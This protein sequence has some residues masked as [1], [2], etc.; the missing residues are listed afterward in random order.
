MEIK[1]MLKNNQK[2]SRKVNSY[3][4]GILILLL[5]IFGFLWYSQL[6][7]T[8]DGLIN[9][10]KKSF[11]NMGKIFSE[12]VQA[13]GQT[14]LEQFSIFPKQRDYFSELREY[15]EE[16]SNA[17]LKN[18]YDSQKYEN[19]KI[20]PKF[21]KSVPYKFNTKI[22]LTLSSLREFFKVLGKI[23]IIVGAFFMLFQLGK[24]RKDPE[25]SIIILSCFFIFSILVIMPFI[26]IKYDLLRTYQ[27]VLMLLSLPA[28]L[29]GLFI[30]K[31][32]KKDYKII[33]ITI[34]FLFYFLFLS[35]FIQQASG[36]HNAIMKLNNQG[37]DYNTYYTHKLEI[38]SS[39]WLIKNY[40]QN[41]LIYADKYAKLRS[42]L[43][44]PIN[45]KNKFKTD[46]LPQLIGKKDYVHSNYAN[47]NQ[48]ITFSSFRDNL[49]S[50]NYPTQFLNDNK[51]KV[52]NNGGSEIYK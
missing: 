17:T 31:F 46:I 43:H 3:L 12:D 47:V 34:L 50:Y 14:P 35:G 18:S 29:G 19:Y 36:G 4:T 16:M 7:E 26:S 20:T 48:Q 13:Q 42:W 23:L 30:F 37:W 51:N 28:V 38:S 45:L 25:Y 6:T 5:L 39:N 1:K 32:L 27:Q 8:S 52:Y 41:N 33:F 2:N 15:N 10:T 22:V 11:T 21:S 24:Q 40:A 49:I 9:F 44:I